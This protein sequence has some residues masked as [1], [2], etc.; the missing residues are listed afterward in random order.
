[1]IKVM[2]FGLLAAC[3]YVAGVLL[4]VW[5]NSFRLK[6]AVIVYIKKLV[7]LELGCVI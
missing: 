3:L 7:S 6:R 4:E 5:L 2:A 1:M